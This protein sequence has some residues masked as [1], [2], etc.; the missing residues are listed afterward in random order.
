[1]SLIKSPVF[2]DQLFDCQL[3]KS[4]LLN[5]TAEM[6]LVV[7]GRNYINELFVINISL[8]LLCPCV[9]PLHIRALYFVPSLF[10]S[11]QFAGQAE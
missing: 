1:M 11:A 6:K 3:V 2:L 9:I 5:G 10:L 8:P 7:N 4:T